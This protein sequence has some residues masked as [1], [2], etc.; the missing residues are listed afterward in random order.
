MGKD[1]VEL[2]KWKPSKFFNGVICWGP[3]GQFLR[4]SLREDGMFYWEH[5]V[6]MNGSLVWSR[7][8]TC[9]T[10]DAGKLA[11]INSAT[12]DFDVMIGKQVNHPVQS[13]VDELT[14]A[15]PDFRWSYDAGNRRYEGREDAEQV[16]NRTVSV[17]AYAS[18][19]GKYYAT[20]WRHHV[21]LDGKWH[22][23]GYRMEGA[24]DDRSE[25][26]NAA[27]AKYEG[28]WA[29]P[30][31]H[32]VWCMKQRNAEIGKELSELIAKQS[33]LL[34]ESHDLTRA[35]KEASDANH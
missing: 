25:A 5:C 22:H 8:G 28:G 18:A 19:S 20:A 16:A 35:I 27:I 32:R 10:M 33:A 23:H 34:Q 2:Y 1:K 12:P 15:Y 11:A 3:G 7:N 14:S 30:E 26:I 21:T 24:G 6:E 9:E 17:S 31:A 13:I 4:V 29:S